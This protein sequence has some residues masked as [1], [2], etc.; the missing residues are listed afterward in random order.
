[1]HPQHTPNEGPASGRCCSS[2]GRSL[3]HSEPALPSADLPMRVGR[4]D[5]TKDEAL[6]SALRIRGRVEWGCCWANRGSVLAGTSTHH[7][8]IPVPQG[9][10]DPRVSEVLKSGAESRA[11][12]WLDPQR[13]RSP[14]DPFV[15]RPQAQTPGASSP[16]A[17]AAAA[18]FP[19]LFGF[20]IFVLHLENYR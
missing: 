20:L 11:A 10:K 15:P 19:V 13:L 3:G 4:E 16:R 8:G 2:S 6:C 5:P 7:K 18:P 9:S 17:P 12:A 1:M 14:P